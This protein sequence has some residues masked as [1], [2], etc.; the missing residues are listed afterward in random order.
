MTKT[1]AL[2]GKGGTGKTTIASLVIRA[3]LPHTQ[4]PLLAI[5][6]DPAINLHMALGLP[7]PTTIGQVR[8]DLSEVTTSA[9][10][11]VAISRHD[12]LTREVQLALEEGDQVDLLA[13]GRP[14]G[15]GCYCAVNHLLRQIVDTLGKS[16]A[17]VVIDNEA[18]MEHISRRTT[19]DVDLLLLVSDPTVRGIR[20]AASMAELAQ[21]L[22]V[23]VKEM[24]LILNRVHGPIPE[25]LQAA[26]DELDLSK[27]V[28]VPADEN[29]N[30]LDAM[31]QPLIQLNGDSPAYQAIE[32]MTREIV[33]RI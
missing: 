21:D 32:A 10:L 17:Y 1:I 25:P 19:R 8:E 6:A 3:L 31:G 14:E 16:Y 15:Q 7:T 27:F 4:G 9:Q 28:S 29:V 12:Y 26:L 30:Q 2:A 23:N 5:D 11:G 13:M 20:T 22:E 18:G 33:K 24:M